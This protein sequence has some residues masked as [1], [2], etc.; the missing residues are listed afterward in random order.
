MATVPA[1][2]FCAPARAK[3]IAAL[4][5]MPGVCGVLP[6]SEEPG[7]TRTPSCFQRGSLMS[8]PPFRGTG[9]AFGLLSG[10]EQRLGLVD[11]FLLL[12]LRIGI[13]DDTGAGLHVHVAVL[14][15]RGAQHDRGIHVT[16]SG[17]I[18]D[19]AGIKAALFL[20]KLVD[21]LHRPHLGG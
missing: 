21:D 14:D 12:G 18:T 19:R 13:G 1:H 11:A 10:A 8:L 5:S 9:K 4:R 15:E 17:E 20:L 7:I 16:C 6:S 2:S 3:L